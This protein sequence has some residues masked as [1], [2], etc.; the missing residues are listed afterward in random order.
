MEHRRTA[1]RQ[2]IGIAIAACSVVGAL[3]TGS[4]AAATPTPP[5]IPPDAPWLT[6]V[7]Y[8][9]SMAGLAPVTENPTHSAGAV[10]H[11][12]YMLL[13]GMSHDETPGNPGYTP[14]GRAAGNNGNVAVSSAT[15]ASAR[16]MIELWM[17]GPFHAIGLLRPNLQTAGFGAC[18][19][20]NTSPWRSGATL[21]V[22][23]GLGPAQPRTQPILWPGNGTT[24]NLDRF[25]A[26][27]PDPR[28][29]CGWPTNQPAGLP[30]IAMMP[31]SA[32]TVTAASM[33]GP[34]GP[35]QTCVLT[36]SNTNGV[37][38][39][40][41]GGDNAVVVMPRSPLAPGTYTVSVQTPAR[42]VTWSFTQDPAAATGVMPEPEDADPEGP[43]VGFE[44][45]APTRIVDTRIALGATRLTAGTTRRFQV[46]G[47]G[48]VPSGATA[49]AGNFTVTGTSGGGYLTAWNC[50]PDRPDVA[51]IN[52][53]ARD[54]VP[55]GAT[56]PLSPDGSIC[57]FAS[58][59]TDLVVDVSGFYSTVGTARFTSVAPQRLMDSRDGVGTPERL[60]AGQIV[61]LQ[62]GGVGGIPAGVR[63]VA[64]NIAAVDPSVAGFVTPYPCDQPRPLT[65]NV[66]PQPGIVRSN[67]AIVPVAADG[68]VCFFTE[69]AVDLVVDVTG[70]LGTD[71]TSSFTATVPF[72]FTDTRD[73]NRVELHAGTGGNGLGAGQV[74]EIQIAGRRGVPANA[75]AVSI[76]LAVTGSPTSGY[77]TAWPCGERPPTATVNHR[78]WAAT[79]NGAQVPLSATGTLCVFT[80][81]SAH[82][83]V[84]VNGWWS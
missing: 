41:L 54:T 61:S 51:T 25:I 15:G 78:S 28:S 30:V 21:D 65:A 55:N 76:N 42:S 47:R 75:T 9:R 29:F 68:T 50:A 23:R 60:G 71:S 79:S 46:T 40:I 16:S 31:E 82:V 39:S 18:N 11:S 5:Y 36:S 19:N 67:L 49:V 26:E 10:L 44:P 7:N 74:L 22:L 62:V 6:T 83:V 35:L 2:L 14:E 64:L 52:Y 37:A 70:Y 48:G 8:Y 27:T 58:S 45:L 4:T 69:N 33:V 84:D 81:A 57:V 13:N 80:F 53:E 3:V 32:S 17:T 38:S 24:T 59:D 73:R 1:R 66:N 63:A 43:S 34:S 56:V 12:C 77:L 20:P 72:R